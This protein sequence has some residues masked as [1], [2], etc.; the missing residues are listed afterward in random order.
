MAAT[1]IDKYQAPQWL[2]TKARRRFH[3]MAK[4][5]GPACNLDCAY[6]FYFSKEK[7]PD[8]PGPGHMSD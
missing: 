6:C 2:G 1:V 4:P 8:G 5:A 3:V 7:L